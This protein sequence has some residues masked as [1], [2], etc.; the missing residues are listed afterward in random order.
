M[1]DWLGTWLLVEVVEHFIYPNR[2]K[3]IAPEEGKEM[4]TGRR[5]K[6]MST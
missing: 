5:R 2:N 6:K 1:A 4:S 3:Q